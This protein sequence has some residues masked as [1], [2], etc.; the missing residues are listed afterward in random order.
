MIYDD[1]LAT[2]LRQ[3]AEGLT[4]RRS[5]YRQLLDLLGTGTSDRN[6]AQ[7][8]AAYAQLNALA[9]QLSAGTRAQ[10]CDASDIRLRN[11]R[12]IAALGSAEPLVAAAAIRH[13]A[14][15]QEQWLD[16]VPA[17]P[18]H[19]Y[20]F[21][22][23]R[24]DLPPGAASMMARLGLGERAL[25]PVAVAA[26][27][28]GAP[29]ASPEPAPE[30]S[31]IGALV[32]K[33]EAY[34]QARQDSHDQPGDMPRLPLGEDP[35]YSHARAVL[36]F[37]F[38]A[39][40][41]GIIVWAGAGVAAMVVG[42]SLTQTPAL[43]RLIR[44]YQPINAAL[45]SLLGAPAISGAWQ[46]DAAPAF[47]PLTGRMAGY[48]GRFRRLSA[49]DDAA[50][51][52]LATDSEHD[53]LRQL[54]HELRTPINAIQGFAEVIQQQLFGPTPHEYRAMAAA[55]AGDAA[56]MLAGFDELERLARLDS[57]AMQVVAGHLEAGHCDLAEVLCATVAMLEPHNSQRQ[58]GF[59]VTVDADA[60]GIAMDRLE[61]ERLFWRLLATLS[62]ASAPGEVLALRLHRL[63]DQI[64]LDLELP[65]A[66]AGHE[67]DAL[68]NMATT[69]SAQTLAV[70]MFGAG[71]ALRLAAA[72]VRAAHGEIVHRSGTVLVTL[73]ASGLTDSATDHSPDSA[74]VGNP[75]LAS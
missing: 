14:L 29:E 31:N 71:F 7:I 34:R 36:A 63:G 24:Q 41:A 37:D 5:Q 42:Q 70:G 4:A 69:S 18:V 56:H 8:D 45:L 39:N 72:E 68:F 13:A 9:Q 11:P 38:T 50:V 64:A 74:G 52:P 73:P 66:L 75:S 26:A 35:D 23:D 21:I 10:I 54:L 48:F 6:S 65:K 2:V 53:R 59:A 58:A 62:G 60:H 16:L 30:P 3:R 47:D 15:N 46:L 1:R 43:Q 12:L 49:P 51:D 28:D 32:R 33:I 57:G 22:R 25:P 40:A 20:G 17:L 61:A 44:Q 55:I 27:N 19:T 67:G